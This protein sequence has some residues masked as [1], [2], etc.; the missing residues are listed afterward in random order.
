[1]AGA[2]KETIFKNVNYN[3]HAHGGNTGTF[4]NLPRNTR[5]FIPSLNDVLYASVEAECAFAQINLLD[6]D[7]VCSNIDNLL[8]EFLDA[9]SSLIHKKLDYKIYDTNLGITKCPNIL[10]EPEKSL[11]TTGIAQCPVIV[12][13]T[14]LKNYVSHTTGNFRQVGDTII[15]DDAYSK[16]IDFKRSFKEFRFN[17]IQEVLQRPI[18]A[19]G[20]KLKKSIISHLLFP[21][22]KRIN[23]VDPRVVTDDIIELPNY[24]T[25]YDSNKFITIEH[26]IHNLCT[27]NIIKPGQKLY[28]ENIIQYY[29]QKIDA[30]PMYGPQ[31]II[32]IITFACNEIIDPAVKHRYDMQDKGISYEDFRSKS[33]FQGLSKDL[34]EE[35]ELQ[36][37]VPKLTSLYDQQIKISN[38]SILKNDLSIQ[39]LI[40]A[41]IAGEDEMIKRD[42]IYLLDKLVQRGLRDKIYI[43]MR[44][45]IEKNLGGGSIKNKY[46]LKY[47]K[48][49]NKYLK[50]TKI[51]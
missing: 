9:Q 19:V 4:F 18:T 37:I 40:L 25:Y 28:L 1:M 45:Y 21:H 46:Y 17:N 38:T 14:Y 7:P 51:D 15:I 48:Y 12:K 11:F 41:G 44:S 29:R 33:Q 23:Y 24:M 8:K 20:G 3:L 49:K 27:V 34:Q 50:I 5:I 42:K 10:Y 39:L 2:A 31:T 6:I 26:L 30:D 47:L 43:L 16:I 32:T 35:I 13:Q 36:S 22:T